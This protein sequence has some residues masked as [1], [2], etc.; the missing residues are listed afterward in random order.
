MGMIMGNPQHCGGKAPL[1]Y[2]LTCTVLLMGIGYM[3]W[4]G[5]QC[6]K[7]LSN[8]VKAYVRALFSYFDKNMIQ[9]RG[10]VS[11]KH[12]R[13]TRIFKPPIGDDIR[14]MT[15]IKESCANSH[16]CPPGSSEEHGL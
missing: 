10:F 8:P 6:S 15:L 12:N 1:L 2:A 9:A 16:S 3:G 13:I 5:N 11:T 14:E 7:S 4:W